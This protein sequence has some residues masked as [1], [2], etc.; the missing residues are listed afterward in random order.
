MLA[1]TNCISPRPSSAYLHQVEIDV[2]VSDVPLLGVSALDRVTPTVTATNKESLHALQVSTDSVDF[3]V[4]NRQVHMQ[5]KFQTKSESR[6]NSMD[7][8]MDV[9]YEY[10]PRTACISTQAYP[11][12]KPNPKHT[13]N[14]NPKFDV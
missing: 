5:M 9:Q 8:P 6:R 3:L 7:K 13:S 12:H 2:V 14:P 4:Y 1:P 11:E 10:S